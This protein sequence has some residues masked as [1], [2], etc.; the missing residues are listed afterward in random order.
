MGVLS[1]DVRVA[2]DRQRWRLP[3]TPTIHRHSLMQHTV[4]F[5]LQPQLTDG[6]TLDDLKAE[7]CKLL[8]LIPHPSAQLRWAQM[9]SWSCKSYLKLRVYQD[10][11]MNSNTPV[12][13][14]KS[15]RSPTSCLECQRRKQKVEGTVVC[16]GIVAS[17]WC[18]HRLTPFSFNS[19]PANGLAITVRPGKYLISVIS[20]RG[21]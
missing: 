15:G 3:G 10:I 9:F 5:D 8:I 21:K 12:E 6:F 19:A 16:G 2:E 1:R 14:T 7:L 17:P 20:P 11:K 13:K 18:R 4:A